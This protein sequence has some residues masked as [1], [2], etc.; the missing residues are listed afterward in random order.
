MGSLGSIVTCLA[1]PTVETKHVT[2]N[3]QPV[4]HAR[5]ASMEVNVIVTVH[6]IV[7]RTNVGKRM[8]HVFRVNVVSMEMNV[9]HFVQSTA[10]TTHVKRNSELV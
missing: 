10:K 1:I 4:M 7:T 8:I 2:Q 6:P 3:L 5:P 9:G